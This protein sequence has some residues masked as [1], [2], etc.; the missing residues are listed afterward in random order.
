[1]SRNLS[2][3][4]SEKTDKLDRTVFIIPKKVY[5]MRVTATYQSYPKVTT[6]Q[7]LLERE[8]QLWGE[9]SVVSDSYYLMRCWVLTGSRSQDN[10]SS[11]LLGCFTSGLVERTGHVRIC[12][13]KNA[14]SLSDVLSCVF[15]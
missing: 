15:V 8:R 10:H 11:Q 2:P 9:K 13:H 3:Q 4:W 6:L 1:M 14:D 12:A 5:P 7:A